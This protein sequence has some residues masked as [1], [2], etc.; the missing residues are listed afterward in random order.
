MKMRYLLILMLV[1]WTALV[2]AETYS[3]TDSN[4]TV[5]FSDDYSQVPKKVRKK[6]K[7]RRD[8]VEQTRQGAP[9]RSAAPGASPAIGSAGS[10]GDTVQ[11]QAVNLETGGLFGGRK[12]EAWQGDFRARE[13]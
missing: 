3:W 5:H 6:V 4:G 12:P 1:L 9:A 2:L 11:K 7:I 8:T 10:N 13:A